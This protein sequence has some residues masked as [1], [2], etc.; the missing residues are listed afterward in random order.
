MVRCCVV[1]EEPATIDGEPSF[2]VFANHV[3]MVRFA[4]REDNGYKSI[5]REIHH[6]ISSAGSSHL[7]P[8]CRQHWRQR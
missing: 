1:S 8:C 3:D 5:V 6:M 7:C 2:P 4:S